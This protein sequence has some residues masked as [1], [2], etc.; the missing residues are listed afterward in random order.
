MTTVGTT[1]HRHRPAR[2][3]ATGSTPAVV[4]VSH[5][6]PGADYYAGKLAE[7]KSTKEALRSLK[8]RVSDVVYRQLVADHRRLHGAASNEVW[9]DTQGRLEACVAG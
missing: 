9:E 5:A 7:G 3:E 2:L 1:P 6:G 4:Q 8:R